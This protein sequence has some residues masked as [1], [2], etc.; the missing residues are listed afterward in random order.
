[1]SANTGLSGS[2]IPARDPSLPGAAAVLEE[3]SSMPF[4][5]TVLHT[6]N[7]LCESYLERN[8]PRRD[9]G[10][11]QSALQ[12]R[13]SVNVQ[14]PGLAK[15]QTLVAEIASPFLAVPPELSREYTRL[16]EETLRS[17]HGNNTPVAFST[18]STEEL[19]AEN[20]Y[21][22]ALVLWS[23]RQ[24]KHVTL[25][26]ARPDEIVSSLPSP[27][28]M[29]H[30]D[31][32]PT[33][34]HPRSPSASCPQPPTQP[35]GG[36]CA[37]PVLRRS[38]ETS[39]I[40]ASPS[41]VS[42][43]QGQIDHLRQAVRELSQRASV[44]RGHSASPFSGDAALLSRR[45]SATTPSPRC[46]TPTCTTD[47]RTLHQIILR[48]QQTIHTLQQEMEDVRTA[49]A[50]MEQAMTHLREAT[51]TITAAEER[52]A[53]D[54]DMGALG[55]PVHWRST[56]QTDDRV[57]RFTP[58]LGAGSPDYAGRDTADPVDRATVAVTAGEGSAAQ[59]MLRMNAEAAAELASERRR[60]AT[61]G[62]MRP[63]LW[64]DLNSSSADP[65]GMPDGAAGEDE[66]EASSGMR[67]PLPRR[68]VVL[69]QRF[70][71]ATGDA[72]SLG[73]GVGADESPYTRYT[74]MSCGTLSN[75]RTS[76][77]GSI[78]SM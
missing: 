64:F 27:Q 57:S 35:T 73:C 65:T 46:A 49:K 16:K 62:G 40:P 36:K 32:S 43:L 48:Q 42:N 56:L 66:D 39:P 7:K 21:L 15:D 50:Q 14:S 77:A 3:N 75:R 10:T 72:S 12:V 47:V 70:S 8:T 41:D 59:E 58:V 74:Q 31:D 17:C 78:V 30:G 33:I 24:H 51:A 71:S 25:F 61:F 2:T 9:Y 19:E 37:S 29:Q 13:T 23:E 18:R 26:E 1:M 20:A 44:T 45:L 5:M 63:P 52:E 76:A 28:S 4:Y 55:A 69:H 22:R 60:A 38:S 6:F 34:E 53:E 67:T 54:E 68:T 11:H